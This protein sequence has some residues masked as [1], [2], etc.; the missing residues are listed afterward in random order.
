MSSKRFATASFL[1]YAA[2]A[3]AAPGIPVKTKTEEN[4]EIAAEKLA[5]A[6]NLAERADRNHPV[7]SE[8][9]L[10]LADGEIERFARLK[11]STELIARE[12]VTA[13][14]QAKIIDYITGLEK[15]RGADW[16]KSGYTITLAGVQQ[17]DFIL[18]PVSDDAHLDDRAAWLHEKCELNLDQHPERRDHWLIGDRD[19]LHVARL[20][21]QRV[22]LDEL[23]E[24]FQT[25]IQS[26]VT[27]HAIPA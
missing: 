13:H 24:R 20:D 9:R 18:E 1:F 27:S 26:F 25:L 8:R 22:I 3:M 11:L 10:F 5:A 21:Q 4:I 6:F 16:C 12:H 14:P 15:N 7:G 17:V 23:V 2:V 19:H